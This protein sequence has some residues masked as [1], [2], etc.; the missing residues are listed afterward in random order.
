MNRAGTREFV[1][2]DANANAAITP[3]VARA[4]A[5]ALGSGAGNPSS[6]HRRGDAGRVLLERARDVVSNAIVGSQEDGIVFTSGCTEANNAVLASQWEGRSPTLVVTATEHPSVL[7]P[8]RLAA[9]RG[10]RLRVVPVDRHGRVDP[11]RVLAELRSV[12]GPAILS[13]QHANSETG[14]IQ[15]LTEIATSIAG[16]EEILFHSDAAQ[17]FGRVAVIVGGSSGPDVVSLSGHKLHAP[18]GIG[19]MVLAPE[20]RRISAMLHGGDQERGL[21]AGTQSVALAAG[22]AAACEARWANFAADVAAMRRMRD[23]LEL[24]VLDGVPWAVINGFATE[25]LPNTSNICFPG[26]DGMAMAARLDAAGFSCSL[27]SAC[28]SGHPE[29][30]HVLVAMGLS[31]DDAFASVRFSLSPLNADDEMEEAIAAVVAAA[32]QLRVRS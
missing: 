24:G 16:R 7:R 10:Q 4:V 22:L 14:V 32:K 12:D 31:R 2:L 23:R 1:D 9:L 28:T 21:R 6:A 20:E 8:A 30:S 13:I 11:E 27:G 15:P 25:R 3:A 26:V 17:A 19:A 18:M 29:P 5:E